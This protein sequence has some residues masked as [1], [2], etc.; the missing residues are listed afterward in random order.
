VKRLCGAQAVGAL[1]WVVA[2]PALAHDASLAPLAKRFTWNPWLALALALSAW[3]YTRGERRLRERSGHDRPRDRPEQ[4]AFWLSWLFIYAALVSPLDALSDALFSAHMVQ[5][6]I[7]MVIAAPLFVLAR[8]AHRYLWALPDAAR[9][10]VVAWLGRAQPQRCLY[11]LTTPFVV[12]GLHAAVRWIWHVP[13]LFEAALASEWVHGVQ[14]AMFFFSALLFW[15]ALVHGRYGRAGYGISVL[16]VF[17][18][19]LHTGALGLLISLARQPWYPSYQR[20]AQ[21]FE[22]DALVDQQLAGLIM[23]IGVGFLFTLIG[24]ALFAAWLGEA[25]RRAARTKPS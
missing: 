3:L 7:L 21:L 25:E 6:E 22:R 13:A 20:Q 23:W 1:A 19:A 17:A 5:H 15:W 16:F 18:T 10:R 14:H 8:P 2:R 12:L 9:Q 11:A 4:I 24:L